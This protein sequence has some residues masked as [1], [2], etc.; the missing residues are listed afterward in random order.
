MTDQVF[1]LLVMI[2]VGVI[3]ALGFLLHLKKLQSGCAKPG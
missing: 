2:F 1:V 3:G